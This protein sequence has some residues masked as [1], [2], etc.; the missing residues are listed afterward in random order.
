[1]PVSRSRIRPPMRSLFARRC[2]VGVAHGR[3][4]FVM[5][6]LRACPAC[7]RTS[8]VRCFWYGCMYWTWPAGAVMLS[9]PGFTRQ[10]ALKVGF[11]SRYS[12]IQVSGTDECEVLGKHAQGRADPWVLTAS[13][14][15]VR[16]S[17]LRWMAFLERRLI[18]GSQECLLP[19]CLGSNSSSV[20]YFPRGRLRGVR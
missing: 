20:H 4:Y 17:L 8:L 11:T 14:F 9:C 12:C 18:S 7:F 3:F 5:M 6:R 10:F 19:S 13:H 2:F 15:R 16:C 1:M